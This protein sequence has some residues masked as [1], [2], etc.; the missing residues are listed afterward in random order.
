[1]SFKRGN[2]KTKDRRKSLLKS[3][4]K[5]SSEGFYKN[6]EKKQRKNCAKISKEIIKVKL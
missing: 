4:K 6:F 1:L 3:N 5:V 2:R